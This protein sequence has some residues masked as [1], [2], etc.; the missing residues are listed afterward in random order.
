VYCN[1]CGT[2]YVKKAK[3]TKKHLVRCSK[4]PSYVKVKIATP[5]SAGSEAA[6]EPSTSATVLR[7]KISK[8][9][10]FCKYASH[11]RSYGKNFQYKEHYTYRPP[12]DS[13]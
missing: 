2:G 9:R 6:S 12:K 1:Y 7:F 13:D 3:R 10:S 11:F 5:V 4:A 8:S